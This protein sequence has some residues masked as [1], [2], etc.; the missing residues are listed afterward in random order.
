M[1]IPFIS[2]KEKYILIR[3]DTIEIG[4]GCY[5]EKSDSLRIK[6]SESRGL[7]EFYQTNN[8][9]G[10]KIYLFFEHLPK[11]VKFDFGIYK[12]YNQQLR[13]ELSVIDKFKDTIMKHTFAK[14][15]LDID[16]EQRKTLILLLVGGLFGGGGIGVIV[17]I[18]ISAFFLMSGSGG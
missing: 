7:G 8:K 5:D 4:K 10:E 6:G 12:D 16:K 13:A 15:I 9:K 14:G 3:N 17:G 18:V 2:K 1:N 11:S